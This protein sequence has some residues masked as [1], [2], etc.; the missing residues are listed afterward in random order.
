ML[1][2]VTEAAK[3]N[4][5]ICCYGG[6][7]SSK[8]ISVLQY[9]TLIAIRAAESFVITIV[10]ES[11][12]VLKRSVIRDWQTIIMQGAWSDANFNRVELTYTFESGA[13]FQFVPA[14][15]EDRFMG[16]RQR[17]AMI[18][19]AYNITKGVFDQIDIR[20]DGQIFLTWN[21]VAEFWAKDLADRADCAVLHSTYRDNNYLSDSIRKTLELRAKTDPNF[22]RVFVLGQYGT[23][24]GLIFREGENWT[25][26][27][28]IP[29]EYKRRVIGLDFG[30]SYDPT[31]I[32]DI[33]YADGQ[34]W[35]DELAWGTG[36]LNSDIGEILAPLGR[37]EVIA[38]SAEPKS[39][40]ELQKMRLNVKPCQKGPDS[41]IHGLRTLKQFRLNVTE[42]SVNLIKE[43]RNYSWLKT[44]DGNYMDR[45]GDSWNHGID[46]VRYGVTHVR[47]HPRYGSYSIS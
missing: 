23:Y 10:G 29:K 11:I 42:N 24:E 46:A 16:I 30:F 20:T 1:E 32:V 22:Y 34:F 33:R 36:L 27:K 43:L 2:A 14:D 45:P 18:D 37:V 28:E 3:K 41:V 6:S 8:T 44:R 40:A 38:D 5:V 35:L 21:P 47:K 26:C 31:A 9:L 15:H 17:Y 12:P 19:E 13:I 39:I 25:K 4:R 7:S